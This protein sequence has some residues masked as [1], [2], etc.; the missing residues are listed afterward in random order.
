MR[1]NQLS[2]IRYHSP[3][4]THQENTTVKSRRFL[5]VLGALFLLIALLAGAGVWWFVQDRL[6]P[7]R[8]VMQGGRTGA[9]DFS[10]TSGNVYAVSGRPAVVF[11]TIKKRG[12]QEELTYVLVFRRLPSGLSLGSTGLPIDNSSFGSSGGTGGPGEGS[13]YRSHA[14]FSI[15][16]KQIEASYEVE[17]NETDSA[18]T[19]ER[20]TAGGEGKDLAAG[21]V[22][23]VDLAGQSPTY[24]Q[25][26]LNSSPTV[27]PLQSPEDVERVAEAIVKALE[28]QDEEAK[29]FLQ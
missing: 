12:V 2:V 10:I 5:V 17:L 28:S 22:F 3:L 26:T 14:A 8:L 23:L 27:S 20:I 19:R 16:G 11:A 4:T 18:A 21:R 24:K 15:N 25:K 1:S 9:G 29:A 7:Y 13:K 6:T